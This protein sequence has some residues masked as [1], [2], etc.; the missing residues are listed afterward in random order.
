MHI[1]LICIYFQIERNLD[2]RQ[3]INSNI[4]RWVN[5]QAGLSASRS[6]KISAYL[7][8]SAIPAQKLGRENSDERKHSWFHFYYSVVRFLLRIYNHIYIY[9]LFTLNLVHTEWIS[10]IRSNNNGDKKRG[11]RFF[12]H[13]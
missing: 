8:K 6:L 12:A 11:K 9:L 7:C 13:L 5:I 10:G 3:S 1:T 2:P 4:R